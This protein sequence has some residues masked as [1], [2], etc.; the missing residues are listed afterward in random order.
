MIHTGCDPSI[1]SFSH[2][3]T[4]VIFFLKSIIFLLRGWYRLCSK[5]SGFTNMFC[6][7]GILTFGNLGSLNILEGI[8][9]ILFPFLIA[10]GYIPDAPSS[11]KETAHW[12]QGVKKLQGLSRTI[13]HI[14]SRIEKD[15]LLFWRY[16]FKSHLTRDESC[17]WRWILPR[18]ELFTV[19]EPATTCSY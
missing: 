14:A 9:V 7:S 1:F 18:M 10:P 19:S 17:T 13:R 2:W 6:F 16:I 5:K 12:R 15:W 4:S 3:S 11:D 8:H